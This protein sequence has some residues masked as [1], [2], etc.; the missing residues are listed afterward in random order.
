MAELSQEELWCPIFYIRPD[1]RPAAIRKRFVLKFAGRQ[2][3]M[4]CVDYVDL[5]AVERQRRE[6]VELRAEVARL[7]G[8]L[9]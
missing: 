3:A 6:N 4:K 7:T 8:L 9:D 2:Q 1:P 5:A